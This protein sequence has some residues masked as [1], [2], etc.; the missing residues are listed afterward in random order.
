MSFRRFPPPW[1]VDELAPKLDRQRFIEARA[2]PNAAIL[3]LVPMVWRT[4]LIEPAG[5]LLEPPEWR[6][7]HSR[8]GRH[9][10]FPRD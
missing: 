3:D 6:R 4:V 8:E 5:N 2:L 1:S 9:R 7:R 10:E